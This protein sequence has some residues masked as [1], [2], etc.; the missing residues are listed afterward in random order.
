MYSPLTLEPLRIAAEPF[1][2]SALAGRAH[3]ATGRGGA[4]CLVRFLLGRPRGRVLRTLLVSGSVKLRGG[5]DG[6]R[7][8]ELALGTATINKRVLNASG[9][10]VATRP[11]TMVH[12]VLNV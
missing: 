6:N 4:L 8:Q 2:V 9:V 7:T 1:P 11:K 10:R 3:A 12:N 5:G